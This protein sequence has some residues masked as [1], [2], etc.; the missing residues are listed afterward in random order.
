MATQPQTFLT[1]DGLRLYAEFDELESP[2][3]AILFVHG[4]A[5]H[6]GRYAEMVSKLQEAGFSCYR[7]D[8]RGHGRS[9]GQRCHIFDFDD[10]IRDFNTLRSKVVERT[11]N[12][13]RF[14]ISFSNGGLISFHSLA[15]NAQGI[16]GL[17][18]NSP[19]FG[20]SLQVPPIKA[21]FARILSR[22][23]P[24]L[25][26]HNEL[27]AKA[28]SHDPDI[29]KSYSSDPLVSHVATA[30]WFTETVR[31][32]ER[33]FE[34]APHLTLPLLMQLPGDDQIASS[35]KSQELFEQIASENK[36]LREYPDMYHE[37][38]NETEREKT[39]GDLLDWLNAQLQN[40]PQ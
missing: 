12:L 9:E 31:A 23:V 20:F 26:F 22:F 17:I 29:V 11:P 25:S 33:A 13:K 37:L 40:N 5:E 7:F 3:A 35:A 30:R 28:L 2:K 15:R 34:Y 24:A 39:F 19:F 36:T 21:K 18:L 8:L 10:Y 14:V 1:P 6:L 27:S 16:D 32:H 38:W 4:F